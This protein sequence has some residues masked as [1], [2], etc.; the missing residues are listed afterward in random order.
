MTDQLEINYMGYSYTF[1]KQPEDTMEDFHHISWLIA[2]QTP[3]NSKEF[4]KAQQLAFLW[5]YQKKYQCGYSPI[6]Q[7]SLKE[8][9]LLSI[10]L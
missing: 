1:K 7:N 6:I 10:D 2:K 4:D 5:Y 3:K 9:D 8:L